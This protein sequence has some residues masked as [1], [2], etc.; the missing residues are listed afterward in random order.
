MHH[1]ELLWL[2]RYAAQDDG[3]GSFLDSL[4]KNCPAPEVLRLR[5]GAQVMLLKNLDAVG[6]LVNGS[7]GVVSEFIPNPE[8]S[9]PPT[10]PV[11]SFAVGE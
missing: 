4:K 2:C 11:V 1:S 10:V 5:I 8:G 6:G 3:D 7:R 9:W